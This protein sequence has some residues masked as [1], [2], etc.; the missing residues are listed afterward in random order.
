MPANS[1]RA[2]TRSRESRL[3]PMLA[4]Y[5]SICGSASEIRATVPV[6][7]SRHAHS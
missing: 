2:S 6:S 7:P 4:K 5:R 1:R 3:I